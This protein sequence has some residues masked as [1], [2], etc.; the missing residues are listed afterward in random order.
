[1]SFHIVVDVNLNFPGIGSVLSSLLQQE[2]QPLR[3]SIAE[4]KETIMG[5][6][7]DLQ[8]KVTEINA[9]IEEANAK[10]DALILVANTTKDALVAL[11]NAGGATPEQLAELTAQ[12]QTGIDALNVQDVETDAATGTVAP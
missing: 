10:T 8:N 5:A 4:L 6:L 3:D 9:Q 7:E 12:L 2:F 1:M 11:Q